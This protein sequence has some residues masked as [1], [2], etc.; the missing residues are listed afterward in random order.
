MLPWSWLVDWV[1]NIGKDI[2]NAHTY[3]PYKGKYAIDYAYFTTQ[4][5]EHASWD[6]T[7]LTP[8][9]GGGRQYVDVKT[10]HGF[11]TTVQRTRERA[12]PFGFGTQLG[13]LSANQF[14]ILV[15]LGMAKAR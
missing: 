10:P 15:A 4:L 14:A 12:T 9:T 5:T 11:Y 7:R 6:I 3:S 1:A 2:V 13:S 8:P